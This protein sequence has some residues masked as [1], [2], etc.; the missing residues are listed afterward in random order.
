MFLYEGDNLLL[1]V[2][3]ALALICHG[4]FE[5][6]KAWTLAALLPEPLA[7]YNTESCSVTP[8]KSFLLQMLFVG[9]I[10]IQCNGAISGAM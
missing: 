5:A 9:Q 2:L 10:V 6:L 4:D 3:A 7:N 8:A 1:L